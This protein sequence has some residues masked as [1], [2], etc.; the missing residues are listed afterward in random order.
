MTENLPFSHD[1]YEN[2]FRRIGFEENPFAFTNADQEERLPAYFVSPPYFSAVFGDPGR[3]TSFFVFAPRGGGKSAQ[4]RMIENRC[5]E[6][7]V[8]SIT[9]DQFDFPGVP[10][11]SDVTLHLHLQRIIQRCVI[12]VLVALHANPALKDQLSRHDRELVVRL[13]TQYLGGINP[14]SLQSALD[15]LKS[16][17]DKVQA[18]WNEWLPIIGPGLKVLLSKLTGVEIDEVGEYKD[19]KASTSSNPKYDLRL[20]LDLAS[21]LGFQSI[22]ILI[23][24]VDEAES[25]GNN[26][27]TSFELIEPL[28]RDLE[29]LEMGGLAFKFFLWDQLE[30]LYLD[31]ARTDRIRHETLEWDDTMLLRMWQQRLKAYS[32]GKVAHLH[33]IAEL[34]PRFSIDEL[35]LVFANHSP[36][37][38]IRIGAQIMS[39]QQEIDPLSN[40]ISRRAIFTGIDKFC[41]RRSG[42][43]LK[44][45]K[46]LHDLK[47]VQQIDFTIPY[48]ASEVFREGHTNTRNRIKRWKDDGAIIDVDRVQNPNPEQTRSVKLFAVSDIRIARE[49]M[50]GMELLQFLD[51]KFKKCPKC[52][53][54]VL[55]DWG[56]VYSVS[57]CDVCQYDLLAPPD[58][59]DW[60][61]WRRR[62]FAAQTRRDRRRDK[63]ES[64]QQSLFDYKD[65]GIDE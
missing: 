2:F 30:P 17:K 35:A 14:V 13:S 25:T 60:E 39:E 27:T 44:S 51:T 24:R 15:S 42:E 36:R 49:M 50:R 20:V 5:T 61:L 11:A 65:E 28:V 37:D 46:T 33:D 10:K 41:A 62:D 8:L 23:D 34:L 43:L 3:P 21:Q 29:L 56:D 53:N 4:R 19:A 9:Y 64:L 32:G 1:A 16:L 54:T 22:Y 47:K 6:D 31:V 18:F 58:A 59:D 63:L 52:D 45:S 57:R 40:R 55:R 38:M 48:L 26:P 7:R 12:G